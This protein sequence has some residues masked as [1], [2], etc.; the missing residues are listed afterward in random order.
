MDQLIINPLDRQKLI[1]RTVVFVCEQITLLGT[2]RHLTVTYITICVLNYVQN[3]YIICGVIWCKR[4]RGANKIKLAPNYWKGEFKTNCF[5]NKIS[6]N[7]ETLR[8]C[9]KGAHRCTF[10]G[11]RENN[12]TEEDDPLTPLLSSP[13]YLQTDQLKTVL[14][15]LS[16]RM[17]KHHLILPNP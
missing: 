4:T 10:W 9:W 15:S 8:K 5:P 1:W 17:L 14:L 6:H 16:W 12:K 11:G 7:C 3:S 13:P 2:N